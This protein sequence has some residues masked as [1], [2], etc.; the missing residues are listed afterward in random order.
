MEH[1]SKSKN[2]S[3]FKKRM[4]PWKVMKGTIKSLYFILWTVKCEVK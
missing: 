1:Q 4:G 2:K 3:D